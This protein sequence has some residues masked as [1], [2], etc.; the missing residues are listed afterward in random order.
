MRKMKSINSGELDQRLIFQIP[1]GTDEDGFSTPEAVEYCRA[2]GTLKTL[3]G[4]TFYA[5]AQNNMQHNREFTIRYQRKLDDSVRPKGLQVVWRGIVHEIV[6]IENDDG[7]NV[8]MTLV[9]KAI[10]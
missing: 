7:K 2:W 10:S 8:T 1:N 5:A 3:R 9:C 6:S 4:N